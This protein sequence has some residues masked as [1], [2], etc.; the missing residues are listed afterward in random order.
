MDRPAALGRGAFRECGGVA[1]RGVDVQFVAVGQA[2]E[3]RVAEHP[4]PSQDQHRG[5]SVGHGRAAGSVGVSSE[6]R[7]ASAST[8]VARGAV[9]KWSRF[10]QYIGRR[11]GFARW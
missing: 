5:P 6:S 11:C 4:R 10:H 1:D 7:F 8:G 3:Q 9:R 2:L